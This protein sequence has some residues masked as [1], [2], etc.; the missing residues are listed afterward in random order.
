VSTTVRAAIARDHM[1][2]DAGCMQAVVQDQYGSAEVLRYTTVARPTPGEGDVLVRIRAA[3]VHIGDWHVMT[4]QPYLMRI[5][6]FGLR[7]PKTRVRGTDMAGTVVAV[8]A[9]VTGVQVGDEVYGTCHGAYAEYATARPDTL[10][11]KPASLSYEQAAAVPTSAATALAAVRD[12]GQVS[13]GQRV[14]IIGASGGVGLFAV[15]IAKALG[16]EVTGVCSTTKIDLVRSAGADHIVDYTQADIDSNAKLYDVI[17]DMGGNRPLR[18]LRR[19]LS[20]RGTLVLV[21]GE[22]GGRWIGGALGRSLRALMLSPFVTQ[23]LRMVLATAKRPDLQA[24]SELIDA[25]KV[26]PII[27]TTYP[28]NS[29]PDA[30]RRLRRGQAHGKFVIAV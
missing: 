13:A 25:K 8:G 5:M 16:A 6:G 15:Q 26:T 17:I 7:A 14:L 2:P 19:C 1:E 23:K 11:P 24:A 22:G 20:R 27:D 21:G 28:L 29:A 12:A 3:G 9:R 18:Q 10:A 4:G 30:I